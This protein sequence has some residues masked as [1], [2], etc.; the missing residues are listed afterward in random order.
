[1]S[2]IGR[3]GLKNAKWRGKDSRNS[4]QVNSKKELIMFLPKYTSTSNNM[5]I[6][7]IY[8]LIYHIKLTYKGKLTSVKTWN[9]ANKSL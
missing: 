3:K 7:Y 9:K 4:F 8:I 5:S 2:E 6:F 1:M